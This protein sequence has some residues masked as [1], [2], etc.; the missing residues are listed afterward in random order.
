MD[1]KEIIKEYLSKNGYDGLVNAEGE[2]G[3]LSDDLAP[4]DNM[5]SE[6]LP[7]YKTK[8]NCGEGCNFHISSTKK[9]E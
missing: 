8:C 7:G 5:E 1:V 2:C 3:C 9:G 6:C 4:C